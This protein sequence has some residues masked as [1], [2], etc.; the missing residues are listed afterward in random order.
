ME[1]GGITTTEQGPRQE[2]TVTETLRAVER[3]NDA[4]NRHE[5]DGVMAMMTEDRVFE[6]TTPAPDDTRLE[7]HAAVRACCSS[8]S[9][10]HRTRTSRPKNPSRQQTD[11]WCA[12]RIVGK[13]PSV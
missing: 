3:F 9:L 4:L 6:N 1:G 2:Q 11:G 5:V 7:E 13:M 8:S 10:P 12:G